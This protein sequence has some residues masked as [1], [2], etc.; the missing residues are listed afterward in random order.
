MHLLSPGLRFLIKSGTFH[1]NFIGPV[2]RIKV[3]AFL[4]NRYLQVRTRPFTLSSSRSRNSHSQILLYT[5]WLHKKFADVPFSA[6][7]NGLSEIVI[8]QST[9]EN[10]MSCTFIWHLNLR[11]VDQFVFVFMYAEHSLVD[12][13][14][15]RKSSYFATSYASP[16]K[17]KSSIADFGTGQDDSVNGRDLWRRYNRL[18]QHGKGW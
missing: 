11:C 6:I 8:V 14:H 15:L 2:W 17:T 3:I 18:I 16:D 13:Q 4:I 1:T 7:R 12:T 10:Q 5:S 9:W